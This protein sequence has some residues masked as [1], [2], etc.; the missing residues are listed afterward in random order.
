MFLLI[1][2]YLDFESI[3]PSIKYL[4]ISAFFT[5]IALGYFFTVVVITQKLNGYSENII[6]LIS[7]SFSL[8][9]VTAVFFVS[10]MFFLLWSLNH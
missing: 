4:S 10:Q 8:G 5:G 7:A 9:L 2:K 1:K 6:G 3:N